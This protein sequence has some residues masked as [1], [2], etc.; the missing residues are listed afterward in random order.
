MTASTVD[1]ASLLCSRLC[2][3]LLS[4]VGALNNGLELMADETDPDMR[5]RCFEL[6]EQSARTSANKLKFFR[7]AFGSAG[8][9]GETITTQE[10]RSAIE[11]II[12]ERTALGW[13]IESPD[14]PK[15]PVKVMLNLALVAVDA[16]VRGG[17]LDIGAERNADGIEIV[18]RGAGDKIVVDPDIQS[19]LQGAIADDDISARTAAAAMTHK[20][21]TQSGGQLMVSNENNLLLLGAF[22]PNQG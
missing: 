18:V 5:Q 1:F 7:L 6:L 10:A 9:Y 14:L 17:Q 22:I 12:N 11:G 16:M 4:P 2:H 20:L 21:A 13:L 3:D 19:A 8:G 15:L